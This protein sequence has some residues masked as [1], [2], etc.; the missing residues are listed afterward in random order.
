MPIN[1]LGGEDKKKELA[2]EKQK[3]VSREMEMTPPSEEGVVGDEERGAGISSFF[4]KKEKGP[5]PEKKEPQV[6]TESLEIQE[7]GLED[8]EEKESVEEKKEPSFAPTDSASV[9]EATSAKGAATRGKEE[10]KERKKE[11]QKKLPEEEEGGFDISLIPSRLMVIPRTVR[12]SFFLFIAALVTVSTIFGLVWAYTDWHFGKTALRIHEFQGEMQL[13]EVKSTFFLETRDEITSL[14]NKAARVENILNNHIYWTK[15]FSLLETYTIPNVYFGDFSATTSG[16]IH[17]DVV[18]KDL[19]AL[20]TQLVSFKTA[21]DFVKEAEVSGIR[22]IP[23]G[24]AASFDL[25][26]VDDVFYK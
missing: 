25:A 10:K 5:E 7:K 1:L 26:L 14:E 15:F 13:L 6:E 20:A 16:G 3:Q 17:L 24:I 8:K 2:P 21:H 19:T 23:D 9:A 22:K 12:S 18:A 11:K 4:K